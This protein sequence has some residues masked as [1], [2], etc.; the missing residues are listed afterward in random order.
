MIERVEKSNKIYP[1]YYGL[2]SDL[3]FWIAINTLFLSTVKNLSAFQINSLTT[4]STILSIVLYFFASKIINKI[5]NITSVRLANLLL[6]LSS[7]LLTFSKS[8]FFLLLGQIL[9]EFAFIF[10][11]IDSVILI[12]NL[13]YLKKEEKYLEIKNKGTTI[14]S[15]ITMIISLISGFLFNINPY[16]PMFICVFICT[17]NLILSMFIV[18]ADIKEEPNTKTSVKISKLV[19]YII[20]IY[21]LL[22]GIIVIGQNNAKLF[23][24]YRLNEV[25]NIEKTAIILSFIVFASRLV[26]LISNL[27]FMKIY[28][29]LKN[30]IIILMEFLL[31]V[32]YVLFVIGNFIRNGIIA[33]LIMAIGFIIFLWLRD[34]IENLLT[35]LLMKNTKVDEREQTIIYFQFFR[36]LTTFLLSMIATLILLKFEMVYIYGLFT[37]IV[38]MYIPLIINFYKLLK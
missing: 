2:S 22:Y 7:L 34:P 30:K 10:K 5:G 11:A 18:E 24:Q 14:Y 25:I 21:G 15:L 16:L 9:Y 26:R 33:A 27:T 17:I 23:M 6:L 28:N 4:I 20:L 1:I 13:K 29:V 3:V 38:F 35:E 31:L 12:K 37:I 32:S 36:K 19:V 8:Y